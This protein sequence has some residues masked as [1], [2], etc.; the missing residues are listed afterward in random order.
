MAIANALQLEAARRRAIVP[1]IRFNYDAHA[2]FEVASIRWRLI[3]FLL[4]IR[5]VM[6]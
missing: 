6:L 4:L 1:H 3:A 5:Y 2:K